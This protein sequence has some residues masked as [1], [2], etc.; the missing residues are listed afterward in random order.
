MV[1]AGFSKREAIRFGWRAATSNLGF[2]IVV[3][4]IAGAVNTAPSVL[5]AIGGPRSPLGILAQIGFFVAGQV[6]GMGLTRISLRFADGEKAEVADLFSTLPLFWSYVGAS[7]LYGLVVLAG[8]ILL[9]VPGAIWAVKYSQ[10]TF[11]VIDK[12]MRPV[13]ALRRSGELT[14]GVKW[15]LFLFYL[16]LIGVILLGAVA[17]F[18]G[19]F[20]AMP[21]AMVASAYV[22]RRLFA[23]AAAA[24]AS[25]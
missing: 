19:L 5:Q 15:N 2:F 4:I 16:L 24:P 8:I 17:L 7:I 23:R 18:V 12:G 20:V 11:L 3:L 9:F 1:D 14:R 22:Y 21:T 6:V 10:Y 25:P 13:E